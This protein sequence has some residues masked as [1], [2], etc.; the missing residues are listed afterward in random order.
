MGRLGRTVGETDGG[1]VEGK[2]VGYGLGCAVVGQT[3]RPKGLKTGVALGA[4][5]GIAVS[6]PLGST[7]GEDIEAMLGMSLGSVDGAS[8]GMELGMAVNIAVGTLDGDPLG[9]TKESTE[10]GTL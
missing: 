10:G 2:A 1:A 4:E 3:L 6:I 9:V 8:V 5:D 7:D